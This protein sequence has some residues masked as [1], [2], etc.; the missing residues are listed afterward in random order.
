MFC[1]YCTSAELLKDASGSTLQ[2]LFSSG[3]IELVDER[4]QGKGGKHVLMSEVA[5]R[6]ICSILP[7]FI[8]LYSTAWWK[9]VD[10]SR[11]CAFEIFGRGT[12]HYTW[13]LNSLSNT[14][15][16]EFIFKLNGVFH[17][18]KQCFVSSFTLEAQLEPDIW[19]TFSWT[20]W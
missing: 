20:Q 9:G 15:T 7:C 2:Y 16:Q 12:E 19:N 11:S 1:L 10:A 5:N 8:M 14:I 17:Y 18:I 4:G 13:L 6:F 3:L